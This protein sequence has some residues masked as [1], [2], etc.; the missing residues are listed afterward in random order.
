M[1]RLEDEAFRSK[2]LIHIDR[3]IN[4]NPLSSL[5]LHPACAMNKSKVR[6]QCSLEYLSLDSVPLP[7]IFSKYHYCLRIIMSMRKA[8]L[9]SFIST[10]V[11]PGT[12]GF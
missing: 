8:K 6:N 11:I 3:I 5:D 9:C 10:K 2:Y 7:Q 4:Q 12:I 1:L